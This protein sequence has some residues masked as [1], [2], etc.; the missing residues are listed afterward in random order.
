MNTKVLI[1]ATIAMCAAAGARP[2][3]TQ[4]ATQPTTISAKSPS[5]APA[6]C[7]GAVDPY[8]PAGQR[9]LFFQAAGKDNRQ[10]QEDMH[11]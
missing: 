8:D 9:N 3:P 11:P 5:A 2:S 7:N 1:L 4:P 10:P 6:L